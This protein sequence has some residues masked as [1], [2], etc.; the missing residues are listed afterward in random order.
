MGPPGY[1][2]PD[3][4]TSA[5][6]LVSLDQHP[7]R[8]EIDESYGADVTEDV[9][10]LDE[11]AEEES[12]EKSLDD[13]TKAELVEVA[14]ERGVESEGLNKADLLATLKEDEGR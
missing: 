13:M 8:D 3:P 10:A 4:N 2:S 14:N 5:G 6:R 9:L 12:S 11:S 1:G 7:N